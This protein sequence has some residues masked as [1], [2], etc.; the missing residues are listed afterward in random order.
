M[1]WKDVFVLNKRRKISCNQAL[2][3]QI[4]NYNTFYKIKRSTKDVGGG[5]AYNCWIFYC[6]SLGNY[7]N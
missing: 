1:E 4:H 6:Y 2:R 7:N 5:G 3:L